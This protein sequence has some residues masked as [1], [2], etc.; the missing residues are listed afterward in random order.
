MT[1][2]ISRSQKFV[3]GAFTI[4]VVLLGNKSF[5]Q[6][7][8]I[9]TKFTAD[10]VPI[11]YNNTVFLYTSHEEDDALGFKMFNWMLYTLWKNYK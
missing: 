11:V 1:K 7:Q 3:I 9:Q 6:K 4:F 2:K 8:I 5:A 10:L